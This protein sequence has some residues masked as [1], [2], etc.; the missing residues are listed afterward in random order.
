MTGLTQRTVAELKLLKA[1]NDAFNHGSY[2][3]AGI[4]SKS[5]A[6][7]EGFSFLVPLG[8]LSKYFDVDYIIPQKR[9]LQFELVLNS[10][11][12][13][14]IKPST[15]SANYELIVED[16][17]LRLSYVVIESSLRTRYYTAIN[18]SG[19]LRNFDYQKVNYFTLSKTSQVHFIPQILAF[20][21]LPRA[22]LIMF[23]EESTHLG[24]YTHRYV[25]KHNS[26]SSLSVLR[27]GQVVSPCVYTESIDVTKIDSADCY[28]LYNEFCKILNRDGNVSYSQFYYDSFIYCI[29]LS[30]CPIHLNVD[31]STGDRR[32]EL[33]TMGSLDLQLSFKSA[34]TSNLICTIIGEYDNVVQL[35]ASGDPVDME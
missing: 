13:N 17:N 7:E 21:S 30:Q 15:D 31:S 19:I 32:L 11:A 23:T 27:N 26:V 4:I 22:I 20:K 2:L 9:V 34:L 29:D 18:S 16:I 24:N 6:N 5:R 12:K 35:D 8:Y 3:R 28:H 33:Q 1:K 10:N 14:L 25:Y